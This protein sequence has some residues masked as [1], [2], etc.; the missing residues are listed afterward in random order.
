[1]KNEGKEE[2]AQVSPGGGGAQKKKRNLSIG[3]TLSGIDFTF[4]KTHVTK[5]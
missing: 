5:I 3:K 4:S 1:M 2:G